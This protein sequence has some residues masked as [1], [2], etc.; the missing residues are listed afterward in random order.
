MKIIHD[1]NNWVGVGI[2]HKTK[3]DSKEYQFNSHA[4]GHGCYMI[5]SN[6]TVWSSIQSDINGCVKSFKFVKGDI[7]QV[8]YDPI[9]KKVRFKK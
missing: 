5:I 8:E 7:I 2:C 4:I 1:T 9:A 6:G 3:V